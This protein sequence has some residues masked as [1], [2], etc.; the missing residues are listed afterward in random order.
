MIKKKKPTREEVKPEKK[1]IDYN[2][3]GQE[4]LAA[5]KDNPDKLMGKDGLLTNYPII[6]PFN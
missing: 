3:F 2:S 1:S 4:A 5:L 6:Y